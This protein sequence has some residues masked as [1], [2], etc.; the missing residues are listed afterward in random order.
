M[1][2]FARTAAAALVMLLAAAALSFAAPF[3]PTEPIMPLS[4]IKPGMLAEAHTV[5]EGTKITPFRV[6]IVGV[7]PKKTSPK[8]LILIKIEDKKV[9]GNGGV[10]AGMSGSPVYIG[11]RL[12]GAIGYSWSFSDRSLGLVTPIEE[13]MKA[14]DWPDKIQQLKPAPVVYEQPASEDA[15]SSADIEEASQDRGAGEASG[16]ISFDVIISADEKAA[17]VSGEIKEQSGDKK[18]S[19]DLAELAEFEGLKLEP[20]SM[21]LLAD[22]LSPSASE[23]LSRRLGREILP[24]GS[25]SA[26]AGTNLHKTLKP[27]A[28]VGVSLVWG[29][30]SL[31]A[32]GTLTAVDKAGR[33][34]AFGHPME[35]AGAV[36]YPLTEASIVRIIPSQ[37]HSF[38]LGSTGPIIGLVTQDRPEAIGGHFGRLAPADSYTVKFNDVDAKKQ[39][40][41]RFQTISDSFTG[42]QFGSLGMLAVIDDLWARK[43]EGTAM[44]NYRFTGG[45]L[46]GG[47]QRRNI[48]FDDKDLVNS[49]LKEFDEIAKIFATNQFRGVKPFGVEMNVE[50]TRSPRVVFIEKL[51]VVNEK[52]AYAPGDQVELAVTLRPWRKQ[53]VVR[54]LK[55]RVPPKAA[56]FCEVVVRG[57]GIE[58][59]E[60]DALIEGKRA[61]TNLDDLL[62][63]LSIQETNNQ[64]VAEIGGP[65][66]PDFEEKLKQLKDLKDGKKDE[67]PLPKALTDDR[68]RSEVRG[69]TIKNGGLV[70]VDTNY[71]VEGAL[72]KFIKVRKNPLL[73]EEDEI[74][75][76]EAAAMMKAAEKSK[77]DAKKEPGKRPEELPELTFG[78]ET[79]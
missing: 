46:P 49:M 39:T 40:V 10:A 27:G 60:E 32:I 33:F 18:I 78:E 64:L 58:E 70:I 17:P 31:S 76:A 36:A 52:K 23:A 56:G 4:Q 44:L 35:E 26:A 59:P 72:R 1:T 13:M 54:R 57:G 66:G 28:A 6:R 19:P 47:W 62:K 30:I 16:D 25:S 51:V 45:G 61:L 73:E 48:F 38:K 67:A 22:G 55:L 77:K 42:P 24:L 14:F 5:M 7:L 11:G 65:E 50:V 41:K 74:S 20:L 3:V 2:K 8:A 21:P 68:L 12:I 9:V 75:E 37:M 29:D 34:L 43:G 79:R 63:E 15:R 53:P 69:E 71:Y